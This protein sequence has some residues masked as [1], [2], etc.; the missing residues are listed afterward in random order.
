MNMIAGL[1]NEIA[2]IEA[3]QLELTAERDELAYAA[4]VE[5]NAKAS[6]RRSEINGE[7]G[8]LVNEVLPMLHAAF[9][10]ATRRENAASVAR[11]QEG[12]R[13][14]AEKALPDAELLAELGSKADAAARDYCRY[15]GEIDAVISRLAALGAPTPSRDLVRVNKDRAHLTATASLNHARPIAPIERSTYDTLTRGW[16]RP[17]LDWIAARMNTNAARD[18][19]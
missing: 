13:T 18:A 7:I 5:G 14:R 6:K 2:S 11:E 3:R 10:E 19:A 1:R 12:E 9:K 17:V 4:H 16:A 8:R 15:L